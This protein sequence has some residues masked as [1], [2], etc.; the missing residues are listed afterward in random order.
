MYWPPV[1][2]ATRGFKM[3]L[4]TASRGNTFVRGISAL[5]SALLVYL[6]GIQQI[7]NAE[8][9][10]NIAMHEPRASNKDCPTALDRLALR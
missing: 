7:R 5:P 9:K 10:I 6:F 4:F 2:A 1:A 8:H 3:V